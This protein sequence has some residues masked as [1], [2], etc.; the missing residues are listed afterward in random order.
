[1]VAGCIATAAYLQP[2]GLV[3][4]TDPGGDATQEVSFGDERQALGI[5]V[6]RGCAL[7]LRDTGWK[8]LRD[9]MDRQGRGGE[10]EPGRQ[11][12]SGA[13]WPWR[14]LR[15]RRTPVYAAEKRGEKGE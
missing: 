4:S 14:G 9:M 2:T 6:V 5:A 15:G 12:A 13:R 11:P 10:D 3:V 7:V 1:M 8:S